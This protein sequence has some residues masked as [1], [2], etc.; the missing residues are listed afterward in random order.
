MS[1]AIRRAVR[2]SLLAT[3][4]A[5]L[6]AATALAATAHPAAART[7]APPPAR[8]VVIV[9]VSGLRW[10]DLSPS[11]TP[12]LWRL[13][14]QGS[15]GSLVDYAVLPLTCPADAWLT[16]NA[17][18]RAQTDHTDAACR[19][20]P[21]VHPS[22]TGAT[23]PA[24]PALISY[25][26]R[27]HNDPDWG[28]LASA[29]N[30]GAANHGAANHGAA[31]HGA[32]DHG[33]ADHGGASCATAVGPGA[34]LA[35]ASPSGAVPRYLPS[36]ADLTAGVLARCP[37]TVVDLGNIDSSERSVALAAADLQLQHLVAE[38]PP[39]TTLLLTAP[40]SAA[41]PPHLQLTLVDGPGYQAG[42]LESAS[43]RQPGLVVLTDLTPTVLGWLGQHV[44]SGVVGAQL[45][46]GAR[47]PLTST[48]RAL[49]GRDTAEQ[50]WRSTHNAFFWA[51]A[52]ADAAVLAAIAL[53][54]WGAA[55]ERRRRRARYWRTAGV[56]AT[57]LPAGT[58]LANLVPWWRLAHPAAW[59]YGVAVALALLIGGAALAVTRRRDTMAPF[60]II[61]L[62]TVAVLGLDVMTGSRL[63]LETP[64]GLS[65][66][67]AGRF[68]GIGNEALGIYGVTAL[69]GAA[70]LALLALRPAAGSRASSP[71][72]SPA[73]SWAASWAPSRAGFAAC[74]R[75]SARRSALAAVAGVGAF[76]VF[77]SGWPG[78]G[79]KVGGTIAMVPCFALL[80][81][82]V[83]GI[84][85]SW[86]RL[87]LAAV[88]G[89]ALFAVFA[90]VSYFTK[91]TGKSDIGTFA[92]D[93]LHGHA[94]SLLLRKIH[95]NLGSLTVN[96]FSPLVPIV[97]VVTGLMLWRPGWFGL[98]TMPLAYAA[99]PLLRPVLA[100]LWL[101]PVLGWLADDSGVIVPAAAL[102]LALPLGIAALA[103]EAYRY[104]S[105][106][107]TDQEGPGAV[108][109]IADSRRPVPAHDLAAEGDRRGE[110]PGVG[111]RDPGR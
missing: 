102:P 45:T 63:Q 1:T 7:P 75:P 82:A 3:L 11:A 37:L 17:G 46:R 27:F 67:E 94:G 6:A 42:L 90:L 79:G 86:R 105:L 16:L 92:G 84:R 87:A 47:G 68:Y 13:A 65:V 91:V 18:A 106:Q 48:V 62:F 73:P 93:A 14:A 15:A 95:S 23:V 103:A 66:L 99:E 72:P 96:M 24:L 77:A 5:P 4:L 100:V 33:A 76:A 111:W 88:S 53:L 12:A 108:P 40:G 64:F 28:L 61:C 25:N 70:W 50:V 35:L 83:A 80:A 26:Q 110:Y 58:F 56:F 2:R 9:G 21:A 85:L 78:F 59:L 31:N 55:P 57:A 19:A 43:T 29:A 89:L 30:H 109:A 39:A 22:N 36:A 41:T 97:V 107:G 34:A 104:R 8:H 32:A 71:A 60:G 54:S 44:P 74:S 98:K 49:T 81:M 20:F 101:M 52:L 38:L 69:F 10:S 51:Y